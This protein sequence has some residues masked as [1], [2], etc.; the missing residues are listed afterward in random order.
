MAIEREA[1]AHEVEHGEIHMTR[2]SHGTG[3]WYE[4]L[5]CAL[6]GGHRWRDFPQKIAFNGE[7]HICFKCGKTRLRAKEQSDAKRAT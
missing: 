3:Q 5:E 6:S 4:R 7:T 1:M 2:L